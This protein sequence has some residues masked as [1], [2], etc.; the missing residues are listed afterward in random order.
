MR[1]MPWDTHAGPFSNN[2]S[3]AAP[4][5]QL[6]SAA[7]AAQERCRS[8]SR[9]P[10]EQLKSATRADQEPLSSTSAALQEQHLR[11]G[12]LQLAVLR[13][14]ALEQTEG[15]GGE[16]PVLIEAE[17][18]QERN[19]LHSGAPLVLVDPRMVRSC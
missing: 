5:E 10:Q 3:G 16:F 4:Q 1:N 9:T 15:A 18:K 8:S 17:V 7:R 11:P 12:Q 14:V 19:K 6:K 13:E 2:I